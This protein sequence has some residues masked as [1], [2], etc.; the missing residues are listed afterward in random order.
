MTDSIQ[1]LDPELLE[2][3]DP[4][5]AL[6]EPNGLLAVGGDLSVARL[7]IAYSRGIFPWYEEDSPPLWWSPN[8]RL[9]LFPDE[10]QCHRSF[11][12]W[13]KHHSFNMTSD[14]A[15]HKVLSA[16]A[17]G[18][19][20]QAST[21]LHGDLQLA[22]LQLFQMGYMHTIEVWDGPHLVG[23]LYGIALQGIFFGESMFTRSPNASKLALFEL[24]QRLPEAGYKVIDCQ[25]F[26]DHLISLGA[27]EISRKDFMQLLPSELISIS[28]SLLAKNSALQDNLVMSD[29]KRISPPPWPYND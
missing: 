17:E 8:P 3:P 26:S 25:V 24:S 11:K 9:V 14:T 1:W 6:K 28:N 4:A 10:F 23:G 27:R 19:K 12:K 15:P 13:L 18:R 22:L 29:H 20:D 5:F 2:F 7:L 21:W 16:C